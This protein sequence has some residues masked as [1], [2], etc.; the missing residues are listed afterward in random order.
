MK[1]IEQIAGYKGWKV[2][3]QTSDYINGWGKP[4]TSRWYYAVKDETY[5]TGG[6]KDVKSFINSGIP[7]SKLDER[8]KTQ[9]NPMSAVYK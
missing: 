7:A 9:L 6:L 1:T 3:R 2:Y 4:C 8:V 5:F